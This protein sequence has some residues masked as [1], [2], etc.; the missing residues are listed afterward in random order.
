[1]NHDALIYA[2]VFLALWSAVIAGVFSAFSEFIMSA[3]IRANPA[4]GIESM[5][6]INITVLR[7]QFVAGLLL[8]PPLSIGLAVYAWDMLSGW[9]RMS[10]ALAPL[11][12]VLAVFLVTLLGNVPMNQ[13]LA[14]MTPDNTDAHTY[15]RRYRI[16]WTRFNHVR[17]LGSVVTAVLYL[18][19]AIRLVQG[20]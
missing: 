13:R 17:V 19:V 6:Q 14:R 15:W 1:M 12:F 18:F 5:Q 9:T 8:I 10:I 7:T 2:C 11:A 16:V 20:A 3:L 4:S